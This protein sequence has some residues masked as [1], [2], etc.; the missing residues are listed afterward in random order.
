MK[1]ITGF[2][3]LGLF[4][5]SMVGCA[6]GGGRGVNPKEDKFADCI[7]AKRLE[8]CGASNTVNWGDPQARAAYTACTA[9][10]DAECQANRYK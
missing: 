9:A 1:K 5:I 10:T 4:A 7:L 8:V 2:L 6:T 3:V